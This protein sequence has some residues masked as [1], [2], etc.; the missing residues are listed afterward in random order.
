MLYVF[1]GGFAV[2]YMDGNRLVRFVTPIR[3][4]V[5]SG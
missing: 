1:E 2:G 4:E 5:I 3:A